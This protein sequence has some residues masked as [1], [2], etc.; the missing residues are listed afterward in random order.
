MRQT[1]FDDF[2]ISAPDV[3]LG[4]GSGFHGEQTSQIMISFEKICLI[5]LKGRP[6]LVLVV[7]DVNSTMASAIT[8]K[9]LGV[10]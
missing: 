9:K 10:E 8:A 5:C 1:F 4:V 2:K 3:N 6:D 7:G